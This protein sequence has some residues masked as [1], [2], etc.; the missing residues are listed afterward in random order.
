VA[1]TT[2]VWLFNK[3]KVDSSAKVTTIKS[4]EV[5]WPVMK[6]VKKLVIG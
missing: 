5:E 6:L 1:T 2:V 3:L 4:R